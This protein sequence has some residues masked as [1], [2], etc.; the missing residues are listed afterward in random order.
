MDNYQIMIK[1]GITDITF[2]APPTH[3]DFTDILRQLSEGGDSRLRLWEFGRGF[4]FTISQTASI[5]R[6]VKD[7]LRIPESKVALV[8]PDDNS[9]GMLTV[10]EAFRR[11]DCCE[12]RIF[13][14]RSEAERWLK[15]FESETAELHH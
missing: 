2:V 13:R 4:S 9:Q 1:E 11:N 14:C 3:A 12:H 10:Y 15:S 5:A 6:Y 7:K 8:V